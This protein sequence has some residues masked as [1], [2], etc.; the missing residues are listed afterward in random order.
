MT[1][2]RA[3]HETMPQ[4]GRGTSQGSLCYLPVWLVLVGTRRKAGTVLVEVLVVVVGGTVP[5]VLS[6]PAL[7]QLPLSLATIDNDAVSRCWS[8][9]Q[10]GGDGGNA[11]A[12]AS[13]SASA[14]RQR[15]N[16]TTNRE[17]H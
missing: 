2:K 14:T 15:G 5:Q 7:P 12:A 9:V 11:A 4:S 10:S 8:T 1:L 3:R 13:A 17:K 16:K 6:C